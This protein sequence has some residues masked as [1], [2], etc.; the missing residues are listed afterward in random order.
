MLEMKRICLITD[1]P[2]SLRFWDCKGQECICAAPKSCLSPLLSGSKKE[3]HRTP[4]KESDFEVALFY[5]YSISPVL[6]AC[7]LGGNAGSLVE[8]SDLA[9][10]AHGTGVEGQYR[11]PAQ[12]AGEII[13]RTSIKGRCPVE[14]K[15]TTYTVIL[16]SVAG[17]GLEPTTSGL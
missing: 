17:A 4:K 14:T 12:R 13:K 16:S 2:K 3:Q 6:E 8:I 1:V 9:G 10:P 11:E 7:A 5:L 15:R